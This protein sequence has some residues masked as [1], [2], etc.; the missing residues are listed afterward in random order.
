MIRMTIAAM[1]ARAETSATPKVCASVWKPILA[2]NNTHT[3]PR[4]LRLRQFWPAMISREA[5][6]RNKREKGLINERY[7]G[8]AEAR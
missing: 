6:E 8:P 4:T 3:G 5:A 7:R 2:S 1:A